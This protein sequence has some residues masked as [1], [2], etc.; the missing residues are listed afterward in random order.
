MIKSYYLIIFKQ[1]SKAFYKYVLRKNGPLGEIILKT[2]NRI[3]LKMRL[4]L[5]GF[6]FTDLYNEKY[7]YRIWLRNI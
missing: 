5:L 4:T 6:K 2:N 1:N 7:S 3:E